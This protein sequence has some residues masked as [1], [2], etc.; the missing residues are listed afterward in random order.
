MKFLKSF[1]LFIV[2]ITYQT[3]VSATTIE[4][5]DDQDRRIVLKQPA[6][7][8]LSLA[9]NITELLFT[10]GAG[11]KIIGTVNHSDYP[12]Q[13]KQITRVGD[14]H[15]LDVELIVSLQPDLIIVWQSSISPVLLE[16]LHS[17]NYT[18]YI[19]EPG[20]LEAI[21]ETINEFGSLTGTGNVAENNSRKFLKKLN[22]LKSENL[23]K[24][25][26]SVFYQI[27]HNPIYT[28]NE[29][30]IINEV[31]QLCGGENVF[32]DI[33]VLSPR[34]SQE[35]VINTNPEI[36]IASGINESRPEWLD[37]WRAWPTL[38]AVQGDHLYSIPPDFIQRHSTRILNGMQLMCDHIEKAR[39]Q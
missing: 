30:H 32:K 1:C 7:R 13:A 4:V 12:E 14:S 25:P 23:N 29:K 39:K 2:C 26:V 34:I 15:N 24:K 11:D 35:A 6:K 3:V 22:R 21:A 17:L 28:I 33:P 8:I 31:I 19:S 37:A 36:I 5:K 20:N 27:W 38:K 9:P 18:I 16:K 10:A